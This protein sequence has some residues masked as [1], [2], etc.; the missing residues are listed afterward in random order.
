MTSRIVEKGVVTAIKLGRNDP[1]HCGSGQ[2]YK[3]CHLP[4]DEAKRSAELAAIAAAAAAAAQAQAEAEA[5]A[6]KR[7]EGEEGADAPA[8]GFRAPP[9][10]K[11][12][13]PSPTAHTA[14]PMFRRR[15]V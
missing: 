7:E 9:S 1:C 13:K 2:K 6:Q 12:P 14:P 11:Q 15:S 3:K 4:A 8:H 5:A 10:R